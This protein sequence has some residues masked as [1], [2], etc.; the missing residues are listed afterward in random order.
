M[1]DQWALT[2]AQ[3][4][5]ISDTHRFRI[6]VCGRKFGK[7][8]TA[9]EEIAACAFAK[10]DKRIIYIA[11]TLD[12]ARRLMWERLKKKFRNVSEKSHETRL[13]L[14]VPTQD[15]GTSDIFLGS[16]EKVDN[17]RGDEF[18]FAVFDEV[19]D[20]R[21]FWTG[22]RDAMRP[23]LTPRRGQALFMGT[24]KGFNHLYDLFMFD[25]EEEAFKSFHY[26]TYDNPHIP[27]EEI[28]EA[29]RQLT[30]DSFAQ[31]YLADFRKAEGLVYKEFDRKRHITKDVPEVFNKRFAGVDFGFTNPCAVL[32]IVKDYDTRYFITDEWYERG[33]TDE[34]IADYVAAEGYNEVYPDP[35]SAGGRKALSDRGVNVR[36]VVKGKDSIRNGI[37]QVRELLKANRLFIHPRCRNL[38]QE[39]ET[40]AYPEKRE[41]RNED[42]NPIK[43]NDHALDAL[44][45][46]LSME[47]P[48]S[49]T[50][51]I[52]IHKSKNAGFARMRR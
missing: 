28:E 16:W 3:T 4:D 41:F 36:D 44:R 34:A 29:K 19:Q 17:Y 14:K 30:E 42:E 23:T 43:E 25:K 49:S 46:A 20:Y 11:P 8:T 31:E 22:W 27:R 10:K 7:T 5:I 33:K 12:D 35:E 50:P 24:P 39:F 1:E 15:G 6:L 2:P 26:T 45:Y 47:V 37:S 52:V 32:T 13:E 40:Y 38:I 18:D 21:E 9:S 51:Q 48:A